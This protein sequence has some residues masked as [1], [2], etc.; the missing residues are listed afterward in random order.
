MSMKENSAPE[1]A[2]ANADPQRGPQRRSVDVRKDPDL[3]QIRGIYFDLDDTLCT[4]WD[5]SKAGL[6]RAFEQ[7]GPPGY[8]TED[9]VRSWAAAFREF[10][11]T[12]KKTGWYAGYLDSGEPTRTEQMRLTLERIGIEDPDRARLLSQSYM[13]ERDRALRLFDDAETVLEELSRRYPLGLI[14]NGPADIQRQEISTLGIEGY[15]SHILIEGE[16]REGKPKPGVLRRAEAAMELPPSHILI[17]GN[18]YAHDVAP[19]LAAGWR[20]IWVRRATDVPP[21]AGDEPK[22]EEMPEGG[23]P[24]D[25]IVG[26]LCELLRLLP[27]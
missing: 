23:P 1:V 17:V 16:M 12:L 19:A 2:D 22:P 8:S 5:A 15:F 24:P 6:R 26:E 18:S 25:A 4:Y 9:M 20:A 21:S 10:S 13:Q 7:H 3:S 27:R 14:T 11:P